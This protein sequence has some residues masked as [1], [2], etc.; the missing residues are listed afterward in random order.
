MTTTPQ[1]LG[2][3][4]DGFRYPAPSRA[5]RHI[6]VRCPFAMHATR[7]TGSDRMLECESGLEGRNVSALEARTDVRDVWEQPPALTYVD[8]D[9]EEKGHVVDQ[10]VTLDDGSK[11]AMLVKPK[12]KVGTTRLERIRD[13]LAA[14]APRDFAD[15]Y[16]IVN[17]D[18]LPRHRVS[19][20]RLYATVRRYGPFSGDPD[21]ATVLAAVDATDG[22]T[23]VGEV[24]ERTGLGGRAFV[25]LVR[26]V[27]DRHVAMVGDHAF[28]YPAPIRRLVDGVAR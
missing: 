26:C 18:K 8:D 24:V 23:T 7:V 12:R 21:V 13:L 27:V 25:A 5:T 16:V 6:G 28:D 20:G 22:T 11:Y 10:L 3:T 19:N 2:G 15:F 1:P 4:A 9:G 14:Q 17:E